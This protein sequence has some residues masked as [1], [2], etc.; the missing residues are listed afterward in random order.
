MKLRTQIVGYGMAGAALAALAGG[1]GL[2]SATRLGSAIDEA[3]AAGVALQSSQEADMMHDAIRGDAQLALL[4]AIDKNA[5]QSAEAAAGLKD[6]ATTFAAAL[7]KLRGLPLSSESRAALATVE[8][9]VRKYIGAAEASIQASNTDLAAAHKAMPALQ[10]AFSELETQMA[11]LSESIEKNGAAL[12][13]SAQGSVN[14]TRM[15]V[16]MAMAL[17]TAL[18]IAGALWLARRMTGPMAQAVGAAERLAQG[19][20]T[21]TLRPAGNDETV[22]LLRALQEMQTSFAGIV[23]GVKVNADQVASAS[24]QIAQGNQDLSDRTEQQASALQQAAATMDQLGTNVRH[25]AA[26]AKQ[27]NQLALGA[28]QVA[29]QGGETMAQVVQTM[30]GINDSSR[31]IA[32]IIGVIDGIA[33][34]TNILALNAAVEAARAGEQGRGFAVVAAEV[35]SLA[36][37]SADAAREIKALITTSVTRVEQGSTLVG[38]A[39][40]TMAEIV[41][42]IQGVTDIVSAISLASAEQSTGVQEVGQAVSHMDQ[43]TQQNA[44]LVEE[45][46]AAAAS[47]NQQAQHLVQAVAAFRIA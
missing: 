37:R 1:I 13:A 33:F 8:P 32:D 20:L 31:K 9:L 27:A 2:A 42:A 43:A 35:R 18:M 41:A 36:Q 22:A 19:D 11:A 15:A 26:N 14:Q 47:L 46:A 44:A 7:A 4:G 45:S 16:A 25:N 34:Q 3:I 29:T 24:G 10:A 21:Q 12:N 6:H 40:Q 38:Q 28:T 39:G 23:R 17:A 5:A 30:T